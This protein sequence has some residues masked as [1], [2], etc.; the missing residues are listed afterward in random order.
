MNNENP[1]G[2]SIEASEMIDELSKKISQLTLDNIV[3]DV[4]IR[5]LE[6]TIQELETKI[7]G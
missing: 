6:G 2:I 4:V 3:K 5:K 7:N 1:T